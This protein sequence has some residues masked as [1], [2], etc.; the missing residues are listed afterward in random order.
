MVAQR[1]H[2]VLSTASSIY[3]LYRYTRYVFNSHRHK[4]VVLIFTNTQYLI[5]LSVVL[6]RVHKNVCACIVV[7]IQSVS[8]VNTDDGRFKHY[9]IPRQTSPIFV[10]LHF[11]ITIVHT[12]IS[13]HFKKLRLSIAASLG[14]IQYII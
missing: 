6:T 4:I 7:N 5:G 11:N 1:S 12:T 2:R 8:T 10:G 13:I 14:V 9:L 3:I